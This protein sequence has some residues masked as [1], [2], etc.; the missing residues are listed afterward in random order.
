M[1]VKPINATRPGQI[2]A[3][4]LAAAICP[5]SRAGQALRLARRSTACRLGG[6]GEV[7]C[8]GLA[9]SCQ[10][11][12]NCLRALALGRLY[13]SEQ[14]ICAHAEMLGNVDERRERTRISSAFDTA[15]G[16]PVNPDKFREALLRDV[17]CQPRRL[18]S[19][20][21]GLEHF[22]V[23]HPRERTPAGKLLTSNIRLL[24]DP[25][26]SARTRQSMNACAESKP[27]PRSRR[28]SY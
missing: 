25:S 17:R 26:V 4:R 2:R 21:N 19:A 27:S 15:N 16:L 8:L 7:I 23:C 9:L 13:V 3:P 5:P 20:A 1:N 28:P 14:A 12:A 6:P 10:R 18:D 24:E 22:A 11:T